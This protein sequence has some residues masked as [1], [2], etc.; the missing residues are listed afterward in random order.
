MKFKAK[1]PELKVNKLYQETEE[2]KE[3]GSGIMAQN[4]DSRAVEMDAHQ[5]EFL[6]S[7]ELFDIDE[8][9]ANDYA[10]KDLSTDQ[11]D[12]YHQQCLYEQL[13]IGASATQ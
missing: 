12:N 7:N 13:G 1:A 3:P 4:K 2:S 11:P 9:N 8:E 10:F 6:A 5:Q